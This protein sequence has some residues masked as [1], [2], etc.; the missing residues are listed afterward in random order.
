MSV[1]AAPPFDAEL[2]PVLEAIADRVPPTITLDMLPGL[3]ALPADPTVGGMVEAVGAVSDEHLLERDDGARLPVSVF[4]PAGEPA[5]GP[6]IVY[7][8]GGGMVFGSRFGGVQA[9]LPFVASHGAVIVAVDYRLAPEHPDPIPV[10]DCYATL[11]WVADHAAE[12][13]IDPDR[14]MVAGQSAG[15][16][17]AAG[18]CLLARERGGPAVTAQVLQS[19]MLDDR[20]TTASTHQIV[21]V[22]VWDRASNVMAW[23]ALLGDR[24]GGP[25][26]AAAAAPARAVDLGGLPPAFISAGS[27]EVFRDEAVTYASRIWACGGVAELHVWPGGFHGFENIAPQSRLAL[28]AAAARDGWVRRILDAG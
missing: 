13:G 4:R 17:L 2:V 1:A 27:A 26:V 6:G 25:E 20:D 22:G 14:I 10:Q 19:P 18:A 5:S 8:H 11:R 12:L 15:A 28:A 3:R 16:G 23:T 7:L 24:R 21:G 9:Y